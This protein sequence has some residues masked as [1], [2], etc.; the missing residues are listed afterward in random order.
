MCVDT[1]LPRVS[2]VVDIAAADAG[3]A[4]GAFETLG[5][6]PFALRRDG[7]SHYQ[8]ELTKNLAAAVLRLESAIRRQDGEAIERARRLLRNLQ[9]ALADESVAEAECSTRGK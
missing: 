4:A 2:E 1:I 9:G 8:T 6:A 7:G 3:V 5:G